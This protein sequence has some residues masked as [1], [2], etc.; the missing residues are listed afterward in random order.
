MLGESTS[1]PPAVRNYTAGTVAWVMRRVY[2]NMFPQM[3]GD[4]QAFQDFF[5]KEGRNDPFRAEALQKVRNFPLKDVPGFTRVQEEYSV[6]KLTYKG[7]PIQHQ[8]PGP[9]F[10]LMQRGENQLKGAGVVGDLQ[11]L[12]VNSMFEQIMQLGATR[13]Q[14]RIMEGVGTAVTR[15]M[16]SMHTYAP[17][18]NIFSET[19]RA[20]AS[21]Q[22]YFVHQAFGEL[23]DT[24]S[25]VKDPLGKPGVNANTGSMV[26]PSIM[27]E[28]T[29]RL[30]PVPGKA[31]TYSL[32]GLFSKTGQAFVPGS[33][34]L[35][36]VQQIQQQGWKPIQI[37]EA[38]V[39]KMDTLFSHTYGPET[40]RRP[41]AGQFN[42]IETYRDYLSPGLERHPVDPGVQYTMEF[43]GEYE[44]NI[45][46]NRTYRDMPVS[47]P[48]G[49]YFDRQ[50]N[51][52]RNA[53]LPQAGHK[54]ITFDPLRVKFLMGHQTQEE[55]QQFPNL[56]KTTPQY[57]AL[58]ALSA[59][60]KGTEFTDPYRQQRS[61]AGRIFRTQDMMTNVLGQSATA[62]DYA[63]IL[64]W[65]AQGA[66][67][68]PS[69]GM[70]YN[71]IDAGGQ[72]G[73]NMTAVN[74]FQRQIDILGQQIA[75]GGSGKVHGRWLMN[76]LGQQSELE[77]RI[78]DEY[79]AYGVDKDAR[80]I[81]QPHRWVSQQ[82]S[83]STSRTAMMLAIESKEKSMLVG[84][85]PDINQPYFGETDRG[86]NSALARMKG[87]AGPLQPLTPLPPKVEWSSQDPYVW[88][89]PNYGRVQVSVPGSVRTPREFPQPAGDPTGRPGQ[90][91]GMAMVRNRFVTATQAPGEY[92][93]LPD[94]TEINKPGA[95]HTWIA[96]PDGGPNQRVAGVYPGRKFGNTG[97]ANRNELDYLSR[98]S[99]S[100]LSMLS[101]RPH[102]QELTQAQT[103][104]RE[105]I[106]RKRRIE[107][108][109]DRR[110]LDP[111]GSAMV[112]AANTLSAP[113]ERLTSRFGFEEM[114]PDQNVITFF[115]DKVANAL[116]SSGLT[117]M[118]RIRDP[119]N[120]RALDAID[121]VTGEAHA[122]TA[123]P[124][125]SR[126][127]LESSDTIKARIE[128]TV[129]NTIADV[130]RKLE[131]R[132][133]A[134]EPFA[135]RQLQDTPLPSDVL[136]EEEAFK[137]TSAKGIAIGE[138]GYLRGND[139]LT[140]KELEQQY[141]GQEL[142]QKGYLEGR[143]AASHEIGHIVFSKI[144]KEMQ[145]KFSKLFNMMVNK[146]GQEGMLS[147]DVSG[148]KFN[149]SEEF[150]AAYSI[151]ATQ[152]AGALKEY[153][154]DYAKFFEDNW[155]EIEKAE[156]GTVVVRYKGDA[157]A[158]GFKTSRQLQKVHGELP[159]SP[160]PRQ[161]NYGALEYSGP[162]QEP[163]NIMTPPARQL[164]PNNGV[165]WNAVRAESQL[166]TRM[167]IGFTRKE[168]LAAAEWGTKAG[169]VL[170]L[171]GGLVTAAGPQSPGGEEMASPTRVNQAM[172]FGQEAITQA[173]DQGHLPQ[174]QEEWAA[175][176]LERT[177]KW[178]DGVYDRALKQG[179]MGAE[180]HVYENLRGIAKKVAESGIVSSIAPEGQEAAVRRGI[181]DMAHGARQNLTTPE[182]LYKAALG[183]PGLA[184]RMVSGEI[185]PEQTMGPAQIR[186]GAYGT[187]QIGGGGP[188][189]Q[190]A[191]G[192]LNLWGGRAGAAM[193]SSYIVKR[194]WNMTAGPALQASQEYGTHLSS[195]AGIQGVLPSAAGVD[196]ASTDAGFETRQLANKRV[197]Q[198]G[199]YQQWGGF[200]DMAGAFM[201][202]EGGAGARLVS[203]GQVALGLGVTGAI[204]GQTA[205]FMASMSI[206]GAGALAGL[207]TAAAPVAAVGALA[208]GAGAVGM[209]IWN[210]LD[211]NI[212]SGAEEPKSYGYFGREIG[213]SW[214]YA[215]AQ[216]R[217]GVVAPGR[218]YHDE[219]GK[220]ALDKTVIGAMTEKEKAVYEYQGE[221]PE[222]RA[223]RQSLE[224]IEYVTGEKVDQ[225]QGPVRQLARSLRGM[226]KGFVDIAD[227]WN[228]AGLTVQ[229][230]TQAFMSA[231]SQVGYKPGTTGFGE[232]WDLF[233]DTL[234]TSGMRGLN[235]IT[236]HA[237]KVAQFGGQIAQYYDSPSKALRMTD[238]Y[239]LT[240]ASKMM[241]V[242]SMLATAAS[243]GIEADTIV[244]YTANAWMQGAP[245]SS[246]EITYDQ[247]IADLA[248]RRGA[249]ATAMI[250]TPIQ[251][252]LIQSGFNPMMAPFMGEAMGFTQPMQAQAAGQWLQQAN[253]YGVGFGRS[254]ETVIKALPSIS[255]FQ[256]QIIPSAAEPAMRA[257]EGAAMDRL[258]RGMGQNLTDQEAYQVAAGM[259]GDLGQLSYLAQAQIGGKQYTYTP[260]R[261]TGGRIPGGAMQVTDGIFQ[262][263]Y[264]WATQ[265]QF[266]QPIGRTDFGGF[267]QHASAWVSGGQFDFGANTTRTMTAGAYAS[268][269]D[270]L[271][272]AQAFFAGTTE[273]EG[274]MA[275]WA[276]GSLQGRQEYHQK[277][278][279]RLNRAAAGI[280][281]AG[282]ALSAQALWGG[283][284]W[285]GTPSEDSIWGVQDRLR[286]MGNQNQLQ[287]FR[288]QR[289]MMQ[290]QNQFAIRGEEIQGTRMAVSQEYNRWQSG[291]QYQGMQIQRGYARQ[292][293]Q[294]NE[295][296][297]N[298]GFGWQ[299]EDMDEAIRTSTG[300]QRAQLVRQRDRA[301]TKF[302][303][304]GEQID[305]QEERQEEMW[306][307]EDER[308]AKTQEYQESMM[309]LDEEQFNL[310]KEQRET[311]YSMEKE[312]F[313]E[314]VEYYKERYAIETDLIAK[315][316]DYQAAQIA[317]QAA[318]AGI[319]AEM[320]EENEGYADTTERFARLAED[321]K[322][323]V[324]QTVEYEPE[325]IFESFTEVVV[326][327]DK[328]SVQQL[329]RMEQT[330]VA[331]DGVD[332]STLRGVQSV[333]T[334]LNNLK[335]THLD[336]IATAIYKL[337]NISVP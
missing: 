75:L 66:E 68:D 52:T 278:M 186:S 326:A 33:N 321:V 297:R 65:E 14:G 277:E 265:N 113:F 32:P 325:K 327:M 34:Q 189:T 206:P 22:N 91:A 85:Q 287:N 183:D 319:Q 35:Q 140:Q 320:N 322:G 163:S 62:H 237:Q 40:G 147:A 10:E 49:F 162:G 181:G 100:R 314:Q 6:D 7:Q 337:I 306:A 105:D 238:Q 299:M 3:E 63:A 142:L 171:E 180:K 151:A 177:N 332:W 71:P 273:T 82:F 129:T 310:S 173:L 216:S 328:L 203:A 210:A 92:R 195:F 64:E 87:R 251:Q 11:K 120:A 201:G 223:V 45:A 13:F 256:A 243:A 288:Y 286:S 264:Q 284:A 241:P 316:R 219:A 88:N 106:E 197:M 72:P 311:M 266:G 234:T 43:E 23:Q 200:G 57:G 204:L 143:T 96:D 83:D 188:A 146:V 289:E 174:N 134:R 283:G 262:N 225:M 158:K 298:M 109:Q 324:E 271:A 27:Q 333:F 115:G 215:K 70:V 258:A 67:R 313:E 84:T 37:G 213:K 196:L 116:Y 217:S 191:T 36:V 80:S 263:P 124:R 242:Q 199:A 4:E 17:G 170:S 127:P 133:G 165:W 275:A 95:P 269:G 190:Q 42:I 301:S 21:A 61:S 211:P 331:M 141:S 28:D 161:I 205:G 309:E 29:S 149:F 245:L 102:E 111:S 69:K 160:V 77:N 41:S 48:T 125:Q 285:T 50:G 90:G 293:M 15:I 291:F 307:R 207:A 132:Y 60:H 38:D 117:F 280:A 16:E 155:E 20:A 98:P 128:Q 97:L 59:I 232:F 164:T 5:G 73:T 222:A 172:A 270:N 267:M 93:I 254:A 330:F 156:D 54:P 239:G 8:V 148:K 139:F 81:G 302:N 137:G 259:G 12:V 250:D 178:I 224:A 74:S 240:T 260:S 229:E 226:P 261:T 25:R 268:R 227:T 135:A 167:D 334:S 282:A 296:M 144:P 145:G 103:W 179:T 220:E 136:S 119:R 187:Y 107:F 274:G 26:L 58:S 300:R 123:R 252:A 202:E 169:A 276:E 86:F 305:R 335:P 221:L 138:Y 253:T 19:K 114:G 235:E 315:Q 292:D 317:L 104:E 228:K 279:R 51:V 209:E 175:S 46:Q 236:S 121:P 230:G 318:A 47:N 55:M 89:D 150:S 182:A 1:L 18:V 249:R 31:G 247:T 154:P 308:F 122:L 231:A 194:M 79:A 294:Y 110:G 184:A 192:R 185:R 56:I 214:I 208:I 303:L 329:L 193:Y 101:D 304:E 295:Q 168:T 290:T 257:G 281:G 159:M 76:A 248:K 99:V 112:A 212:A 2:N 198:R 255:N 157:N 153:Y 126:N 272:A 131:I 9:T 323:A 218:A 44:R 108:I 30:R 118:N 312:H 94:G 336:A 78:Q 166:R 246:R 39:Q 244:G 53:G 176:I 130:H 24:F 152:G 233:N